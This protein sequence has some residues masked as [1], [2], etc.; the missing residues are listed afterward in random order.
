MTLEQ[1]QAGW[2]LL[3][4]ATTIDMLFMQEL[5]GLA[6]DFAKERGQEGFVQNAPDGGYEFVLKPK[7]ES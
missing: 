3:L 5:I 2:K 1:R 7:A 6:I 4:H